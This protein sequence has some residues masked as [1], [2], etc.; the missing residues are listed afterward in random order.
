MDQLEGYKSDMPV[1]IAGTVSE[2]NYPLNSPLREM[3]VAQM[4]RLLQ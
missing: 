1:L 2:E 4:I 3:S